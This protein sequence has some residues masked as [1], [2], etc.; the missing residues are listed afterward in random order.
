VPGLGPG[1]HEKPVK[2]FAPS[3]GCPRIKS[4]G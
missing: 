4:V 1:I 3:R 2:D